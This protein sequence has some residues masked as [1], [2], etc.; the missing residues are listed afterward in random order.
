MGKESREKLED[1]RANNAQL[2]EENE[3]LKEKVQMFNKRME[4]MEKHLETS[5]KLFPLLKKKFEECQDSLTT[6]MADWDKHR[7]QLV[8]LGEKVIQLDSCKR[9]GS[10]R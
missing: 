4:E 9:I 6:V 2:R 5:T 8:H 1:L 10:L 3:H 7:V